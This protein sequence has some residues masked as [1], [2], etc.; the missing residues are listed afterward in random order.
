MFIRDLNPIHLLISLSPLLHAAQSLCSFG[1]GAAY[2]ISVAYLFSNVLPGILGLWTELLPEFGCLPCCFLTDLLL[3]LSGFGYLR[4]KSKNGYFLL[5]LELWQLL[6]RLSIC[7]FLLPLCVC[8]HHLNRP[9]C[10]LYVCIQHVMGLYGFRNQYLCWSVP[11]DDDR[12]SVVQYVSGSYPTV[13]EFQYHLIWKHMHRVQPSHHLYTALLIEIHSC[14]WIL[15]VFLELWAFVSQIPSLTSQMEKMWQW[16]LE[17]ELMS[18]RAGHNKSLRLCRCTGLLIRQKKQSWTREKLTTDLTEVR[19]IF[20]SDKMTCGT[21]AAAKMTDYC[22]CW[23]Q[24]FKCRM[25]MND[26]VPTVSSHLDLVWAPAH[27]SPLA[28]CLWYNRLS[29]ALLV[30]NWGFVRDQIIVL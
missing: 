4:L 18:K 8:P 19:D 12:Q 14:P 15:D 13:L 6:C 1:L 22:F 27:F 3:S 24:N 5:C 17:A 30:T 9:A 21:E 28:F 10:H 23:G 25:I 20:H 26:N 16:L 2:L 29:P 11:M 7:L